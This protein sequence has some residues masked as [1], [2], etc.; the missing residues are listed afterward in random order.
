MNILVV[1]GTDLGIDFFP[2][3]WR[4][5]VSIM[6]MQGNLLIR[7]IYCL[8]CRAFTLTHSLKM[9]RF[10]PLTERSAAR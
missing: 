6:T 10:R 3:E 9:G 5:L 8:G 4:S 2:R 1:F 7:F